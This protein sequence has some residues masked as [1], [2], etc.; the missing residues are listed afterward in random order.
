MKATQDNFFFQ[1]VKLFFFEK[2]KIK[3]TDEGD[4]GVSRNTRGLL[5]Q[6]KSSINFEGAF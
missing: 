6:L 5:S 1:F 2:E 3:F 4:V